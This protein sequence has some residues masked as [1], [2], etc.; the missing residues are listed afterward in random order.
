MR[1]ACLAALQLGKKHAARTPSSVVTLLLQAVLPD[2][3]AEEQLY[4]RFSVDRLGRA[5]PSAAR[6]AADAAGREPE[7]EI[8]LFVAPRPRVGG[9]THTRDASAGH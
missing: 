4:L 7:E 3:E 9:H 5:L 6:A 2:P 8:G 1:Y